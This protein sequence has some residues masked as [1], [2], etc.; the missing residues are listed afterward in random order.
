VGGSLFFNFSVVNSAS[1]EGLS[2]R[3][4]RICNATKI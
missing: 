3:L 1:G 4:W 2:F